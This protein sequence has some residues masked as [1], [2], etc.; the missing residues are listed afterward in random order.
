MQIFALIPANLIPANLKPVVSLEG[1]ILWLRWT[2]FTWLAFLISLLFVKIG[3]EGDIWVVESLL[4]GGLIGLAQ[5][6]VLRPYLPGAHRWIVASALGWGA[7]TLF[8]IGTVGWIVPGTANLWLRGLLGILYGGYAGLALG[9]SQ[10]LAIRQQVAQAWRWIPLSSGS[11]AV[12]I[13]L[14]WLIGG[15]LRATSHLFVSE[16]IGLGVA[17]GAIAALSGLGIV[18]LLQSPDKSD[19]FTHEA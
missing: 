4:G 18:G 3:E 14:G 11:W 19:R 2:V 5:W 15:G 7:L 16:V 17:W 12:A 13:A 8:H 9:A 10:W 6:Q 1:F